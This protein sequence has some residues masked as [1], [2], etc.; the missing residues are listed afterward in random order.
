MDN[1]PAVLSP[2]QVN[3]FALYN[4]AEIANKSP[5]TI[6]HSGLKAKNK[7]GVCLG[8]KALQLAQRPVALLFA[9]I[10]RVSTETAGAKLI[11]YDAV[12]TTTLNQR[13]KEGIAAGKR[14][15]IVTIMVENS[16]G[17]QPG[18][19]LMRAPFGEQFWVQSVP[20]KNQVDALRVGSYPSMPIKKGALLV[21]AGN[22]VPEGSTRRLGHYYFNAAYK[23]SSVIVR[24]GWAATGT[25]NALR[26]KEGMKDLVLSQDRAGMLQ[27]HAIDINKVLLY[28]QSENMMQNGLPFTMAD[29]V[30][31]AVRLCAPQNVVNIA[32]P[33]DLRVIGR[34]IQRLQQTPASGGIPDVLQVYCDYTSYEAWQLLGD[35]EAG[36]KVN[37]GSNTVG[38]VYSKFIAGGKSVEVIY[39]EGLNEHAAAHGI[40]SGFMYFFNPNSVVIDY[41]PGR[42]QLT[43][44]YKGMEAKATADFNSVDLTAESILSEF[45]II[46][47]AP[48]ANGIITGF[49]PEMV[50]NTKVL[51]TAS[52]PKSY[53]DTE[54]C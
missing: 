36:I 51:Y 46:H 4:P 22:A 47:K 26:S 14:G 35:I 40:G 7:H 53:F 23:S 17:L 5:A 33:I 2:K 30:I 43:A 1:T 3:P 6:M 54:V 48:H 25:V 10:D 42:R 28:G 16:E 50:K 15:D 39:D 41:L 44:S 45:H 24:N 31:S 37:S 32:A 19:L 8:T 9:M 34:F 11:I 12:T 38:M 27:D 52:A 20:S 21:H 13:V 49:T 18:D 29:G